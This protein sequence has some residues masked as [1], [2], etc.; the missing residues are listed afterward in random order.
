MTSDIE[1]LTT[2]KGNTIFLSIAEFKVGEVKET[3]MRVNCSKATGL[4]GI[5]V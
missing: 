1:E 4:H 5:L 2:K 3:L